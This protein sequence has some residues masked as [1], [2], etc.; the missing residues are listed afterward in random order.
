MKH[1]IGFAIDFK[2]KLIYY[3]KHHDTSRELTLIITTLTG[4]SLKAFPPTEKDLEVKAVYKCIQWWLELNFKGPFNDG[5]TMEYGV[6][7]DI[8][9]CAI[10]TANMLS[11]IIFG[12]PLWNTSTAVFERVQ[13]F[14][15]LTKWQILVS[16]NNH[17]FITHD[18]LNSRWLKIRL[19]PNHQ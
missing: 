16:I 18:L 5:C 4:D 14:N 9:S 19:A 6:Q 12:D 10:T 1:Y 8:V 2:K 17:W 7:Q 11:H 13:W 3:G 15:R